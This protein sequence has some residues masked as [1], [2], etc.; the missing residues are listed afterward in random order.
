MA[1]VVPAP[2]VEKAS[3][4]LAAALESLV[5]RRSYLPP[6]ERW[7]IALPLVMAT[8]ITMTNPLQ[9]L[10]ALGP[11]KAV[12]AG[13]AEDAAVAEEAVVAA[14]VAVVEEEERGVEGGGEAKA[15][16]ET[17]PAA[18]AVGVVAMTEKRARR[19]RRKRNSTVHRA[20]TRSNPMD[21]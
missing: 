16:E 2:E 1:R 6:M 12:V 18:A 8:T 19:Q 14:V 13:E 4:N 20:G 9:P 21:R 17:I 11:A 5:R 10:A 7:S 3:T 15:G